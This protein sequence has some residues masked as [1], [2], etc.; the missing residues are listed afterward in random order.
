MILTFDGFTNF[1]TKT[2]K[3]AFVRQCNYDAKKNNDP[4]FKP[5]GGNQKVSVGAGGEAYGIAIDGNAKSAQK[6]GLNSRICE[7][8]VR[9]DIRVFKGFEFKTI[10]TDDG[11]EFKGECHNYLEHAKA[12]NEEGAPSTGTKRRGGEVERF[13]RTFREK[14]VAYAKNM[15]KLKMP[16]YFKDAIPKILEEYNFIDDHR[17]INE[18]MTRYKEKGK[19]FCGVYF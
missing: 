18:I 12:K 1:K 6:T 17:S 2:K 14:Y 7:E 3:G 9:K 4:D 15:R 10:Y 13:N 16:S 5:K 11:G 19:H 8:E